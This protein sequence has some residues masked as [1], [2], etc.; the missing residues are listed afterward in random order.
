MW[1]KPS[2]PRV[3]SPLERRWCTE[4]GRKLGW[5]EGARVEHLIEVA[6]GDKCRLAS[7]FALVIEHS[8][9]TSPSS[10]TIGVVGLLQAFNLL[11]N[12]S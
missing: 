4:Q 3:S 8:R 12:L 9:P 6:A 11:R 1:R 5:E 7:L 10:A 2:G